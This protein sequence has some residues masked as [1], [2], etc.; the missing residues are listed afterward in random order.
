MSRY[1][2]N[3]KKNK[4]NRESLNKIKTYSS[5]RATPKDVHSIAYQVFGALTYNHKKEPTS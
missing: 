3:K 2:K 4:K 5:S 1:Q